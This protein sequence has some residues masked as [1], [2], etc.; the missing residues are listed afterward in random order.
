[1]SLYYKSSCVGVETDQGGDTWE[2][3]YL[4]AWRQLGSSEKM[5]EFREEKAGAGHGPKA[6]RGAVMLA[7]YEQG[8]FV[9]VLGTHKV[10]E[11]ALKR[12][13][14]RKPFDL[15]DAA[16]WSYYDLTENMVTVGGGKK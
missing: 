16:Y 4:E 10:L 8:K 7:A 1:M 12:F 3:V 14:V 9:H 6:H 13:L 5:P 15:V 11:K 2:I